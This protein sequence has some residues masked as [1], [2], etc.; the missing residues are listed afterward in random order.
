MNPL[1]NE[2]IARFDSP[3]RRLDELLA[4]VAPNPR[5]TP[6]V[7]SVGEPQDA[8]PPLLAETIAAHAHL[9]N[10]Y[11]PAVGTPEFRARGA[12]LSRAPLPGDARPDRSR[13]RDL[14]GH[15]QPRGPVPRR[16]DRDR[17]RRARRRSR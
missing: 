17:V 11:P 12:G 7:M 16:V 14:A 8:P 1:L 10:R 9:W 5:L 6:I 3:F 13:C 4:G 15:E 2:R